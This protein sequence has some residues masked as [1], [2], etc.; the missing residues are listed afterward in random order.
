MPVCR[1]YP[2]EMDGVTYVC[3]CSRKEL[4]DEIDDCLRDC[5]DG[6]VWDDFYAWVEYF[7]GS[8]FY[9]E[10][11]YPQDGRF[12]K[13]NIKGIIIDEFDAE[14]RVYGDYRMYD[15]NMNIELV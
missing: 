12:V 14:Y 2:N 11:G 3:E 13:I 10:D 1:E 9:I 4:V 15:G 8:Y 5:R 6:Y 7:D